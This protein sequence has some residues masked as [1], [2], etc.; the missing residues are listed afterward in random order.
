MEENQK[1]IPL[2]FIIPVIVLVAAIAILIVLLVSGGK[3]E[4][5]KPTESAALES[6]PDGSEEPGESPDEETEPTDPTE[7]T[8]SPALALTSYTVLEAMPTDENMSAVVALNADGAQIL[9]NS[10][11]QIYYWMQFYNFL[12]TYGDYA[13][14]LGLDT[15]KPLDQ[16]N[17]M[18]E[19][20]TWEQYF[21]QQA[22]NHFHEDYALAQAALANGYTLTAEDEANIA[23]L[24]DPEGQ[25][26]A[27][28]KGFGY[29][30]VEKYLQANFGDGVGVK[31]YQDYL[32]TYYGA[33][34]YYMDKQD[35][36][37]ATFSKEDVEAH[38]D[39][40]AENFAGITK[41]DKPNVSI[42][43]ILISV[44]GEK[45][46]ND[47]F[48]AEAWAAAEKTANDI[49]NTWLSNP[50]EEYFIEL[51]KEHSTDPGSKDNGGLYEDVYVG[52]MVPEFNDWCFADGRKP[53]DHGIVKSS[54][55]GYHIMYFVKQGDKLAWYETALQDL[56]KLEMNALIDE[57]TAKY[58]IDFKY[59]N[60]RIFDM[61]TSRV[62]DMTTEE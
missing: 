14:M 50:T 11:L 7:P 4:N 61:I 41:T 51:A 20:L 25:F 32:R 56:I 37:K 1:K 23:D 15:S 53:G 47:E 21:L 9:T 10:R 5:K 8:E 17:S 60:V 49:Y 31:D 3:D 40:N 19:G 18:A 27:E 22:A 57:V 46:E 24:E 58:P 26:A 54:D 55:Y 42:R 45:D 30:S 52:Q 36:V 2:W 44:E 13:A 6:L 28:A 16:Q 48:T 62:E 38:F 43:H 33:Y 39:S 59:A 29:D 12:S 35:A 34:G